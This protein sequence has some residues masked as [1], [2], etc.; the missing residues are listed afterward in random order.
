MEDDEHLKLPELLRPGSTL[1]SISVSAFLD[2]VA[3]YDDDLGAGWLEC[4]NL[5]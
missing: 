1:L 3:T 5:F 4:M 2:K